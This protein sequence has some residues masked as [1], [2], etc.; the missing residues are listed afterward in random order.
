MTLRK[1]GVGFIVVA[2]LGTVISMIVDFLPSAKAGIQSTQILGIEISV[3]ILLIGI[4]ITLAA[5]DENFDLG[6]QVRNFMEQMINLPVIAWV[7]L[8]FLII[9]I[10]FFVGPMFLNST[11]RMEYF[12]WYV[13]DR[14]PIGNDLII[15]LELMKGWFSTGQS[16]YPL[17]FYPPFTYMFFAPLLLFDNYPVLYKFFTLCTILSYYLLA[18]ILPVKIADKKKLALIL[19]FFITGLTS[20]GFQF[21]L[22]RGQYN[23]F[24]FLLCLWAIYIF[25]YHPKYRIIAYLLF[26]LSVQLKLYPAIFIVM[27]ID[28]WKSWKSI[29]L[30][31]AGL[32]LFNLLLLLIMGYRIFLDF[33]NSVSNQIAAPGWTWIG[34]HSIKAF[35]FN[36]VKDGFRIIGSSTLD[37]LQQN[38]GFIE[39]S[40]FLIFGIFLVTAILISFARNR[41]GID[42][43]LLITCMIGALIIPISN[44]YTLSILGSP[45]ALALSSVPEPKSIPQKLV[46]ITM[47]LGISVAYASMLIPFKFKPYYLHNAFPALF[48]VLLFFTVL[49]LMRYQNTETPSAD[50]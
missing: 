6:Q 10:L 39:T 49:N 11:L 32:A 2:I 42:P 9:Y 14:Y 16:P 29:L 45:V 12:R 4:W 40:L 5:R 13:P 3:I 26:S 38:S 27:L 34:N 33:L 46:S 1:L 21:E 25:H 8:G 24:T 35:V 47:V 36:L 18:F 41:A 23:V 19:L 50:I 20:Y 37:K 15:I 28:N 48:F 22:E 30:R 44:D 31:F 7:V 17:Q 43:Y